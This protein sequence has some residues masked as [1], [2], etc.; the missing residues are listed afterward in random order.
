MPT[1]VNWFKAFDGYGEPVSVTY[2]GDAT[3]KT[4][5][6]A[7]LTFSMRSFMLLFSVFGIFELLSYKNPQV[8]QFRIYDERTD[9]NEL[10]YGEAQADLIFGMYNPG[11]NAFVVPDPS[12][13]SLNFQVVQIDW[14]SQNPFILNVVKDLEL[15][16]ILP[17]THPDMFAHDNALN[18]YDTTGLFGIKNPAEVALINTYN[19][20]LNQF[21]RISVNRC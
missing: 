18:N 5:G 16:S 14:A 12:I 21:L 11:T 20:A 2:K 13:A 19:I 3:Y 9:G 10:N 7:L 1:F 17:D 6:G 8:N 4:P 15:V